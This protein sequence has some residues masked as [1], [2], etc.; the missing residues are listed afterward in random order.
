MTG[1]FLNIS[2]H[3]STSWGEKQLHAARSWGNLGDEET[4]EIIDIPF[5]DV[6]PN[7]CINGIESAAKNLIKDICERARDGYWDSY[8]PCLVQGEF[9]LTFQ[10]VRW[11]L[12][13]FE[14]H[15]TRGNYLMFRDIRFA[16]LAATSSRKVVEVNEGGATRK[17]AV[18][19]FIQFREYS[20][21]ILPVEKPQETREE[22]EADCKREAGKVGHGRDWADL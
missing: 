1:I 7:S 5:P 16:P 8:I 2:N 17:T 15:D 22:F 10:I 21:G 12:A 18:F 11:M 6:N 4:L 13:Q 14:P 20:M 9:T 19:E 3:P